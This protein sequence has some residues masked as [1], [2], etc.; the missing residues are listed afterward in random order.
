MDGE[1]EI[2]NESV[3]ISGYRAMRTRGLIAR[4]PI[5]GCGRGAYPPHVSRA[6]ECGRECAVRPHRCVEYS[7]FRQTAEPIAR[8]T[9]GSARP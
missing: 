3:K 9:G 4:A 1:M 8:Q 7:K 6:R 5:T 2:R